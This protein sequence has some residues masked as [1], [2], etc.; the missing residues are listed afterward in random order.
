MVNLEQCHK[1]SECNNAA[2]TLDEGFVYCHYHCLKVWAKSKACNDF[3]DTV[4]F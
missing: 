2:P 3:D 4:I 1:C